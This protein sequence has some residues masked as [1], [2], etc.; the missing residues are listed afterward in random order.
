MNRAAQLY[1]GFVLTSAIAGAAYAAPQLSPLGYKYSRVES[2][3][4]FADYGQCIVARN[5]LRRQTTAFLRAV[6]MTPEWLAAGKKLAVPDCLSGLGGVRMKFQVAAL[7]PALFAAL[8]RRD[9]GKMAPAAMA[10]DAPLELDRLYDGPVTNFPPAMLEQLKFGNCVARSNSVAV[11][12]LLVARPWSKDEDA[13]LPALKDAM[14]GCLPAGS[15]LR[16]GRSAVRG[17][18]AEAMYH[19]ASA[20]A[21]GSAPAPAAVSEKR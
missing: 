3:R 14:A 19:L 10:S 16:L 7:R 4:A 8:Y 9:F 5:G 15:T 6:P 17:V 13:A 11:H 21:L 2:D 1:F 18:L 20:H 12:D